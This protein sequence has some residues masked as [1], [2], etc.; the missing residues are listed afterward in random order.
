[1][2][3]NV[4]VLLITPNGDL[5]NFYLTSFLDGSVTYDENTDTWR[6]GPT[7]ASAGGSPS[8]GQHSPTP[9]ILQ[10]VRP[11]RRRKGRRR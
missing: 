3:E 7:P 6:M 2:L 4:V 8:G 5:Y 9:I 1:M 11:Q 10:M